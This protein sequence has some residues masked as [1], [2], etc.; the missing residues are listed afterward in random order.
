M[1][2]LILAA[3]ADDETVGSG[4]LIQ[5]LRAASWR[6]DVVVLGDGQPSDRG[7]RQDNREDCAK[8]CEMLG[9]GEP[10]FLGFPDQHLDEV[11]VADIVNHVPLG[12]REEVSLIVTQS[13]TDLNRDHQVAFDVGC[14]VARRRRCTLLAAETPGY[15]SWQGEAFQANF[16][17][18]LRERQVHTKVKAFKCYRN[19][20]VRETDDPLTPANLMATATVRGS[21]AGCNYAEAFQLVRSVVAGVNGRLLV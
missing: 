3:H 15:A 10:V 17:M 13:K 9:V 18:P 4:G 8:A 14:I 11:A 1:R 19:E 12:E 20:C 5:R 21:E 16:Y 2:A 7:S 6:V